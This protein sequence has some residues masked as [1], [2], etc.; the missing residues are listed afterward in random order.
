M[1]SIEL[2]IL[3]LWLEH[4]GRQSITVHANHEWHTF[5]HSVRRCLTLNGCFTAAV[6]SSKDK[7]L[8]LTFHNTFLMH[9]HCVTAYCQRSVL[10]LFTFKVST[11]LSVEAETITAVQTP[12][13]SSSS[14]Y[15]GMRIYQY[16]LVQLLFF[17]PGV[18]TSSVALLHAEEAVF[19]QHLPCSTD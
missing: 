16:I 13:S 14:S 2:S 17:F 15:Q 10:P 3:S 19:E 9:Y 1:C 12:I 18:S 8:N 11:C 6:I 4:A 5:V 7:A